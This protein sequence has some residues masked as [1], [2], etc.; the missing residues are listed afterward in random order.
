MT[1]NRSVWLRQGR[2]DTGLLRDKKTL[3]LAVSLEIDI[4]IYMYLRASRSVCVKTQESRYSEDRGETADLYRTWKERRYRCMCADRYVCLYRFQNLE[5]L[6]TKMSTN[7]LDTTPCTIHNT[8]KK[9]KKRDDLSRASRAKKEGELQ[10]YIHHARDA[11]QQLQAC[12]HA[13][14]ENTDTQIDVYLPLY[15]KLYRLKRM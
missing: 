9:K 4:D 3:S 14:K 8:P 12:M 10:V 1:E 5:S 2:K 11:Q 13:S 7:I 15:A 6:C